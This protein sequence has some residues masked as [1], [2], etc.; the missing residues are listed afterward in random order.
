M[1]S[2][3]FLLPQHLNL[4]MK[5][6]NKFDIDICHHTAKPKSVPQYGEMA[7]NSNFCLQFDLQFLNHVRI[8]I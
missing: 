7:E 1:L 6:Q 2:V 5:H 8:I 3:F 4:T